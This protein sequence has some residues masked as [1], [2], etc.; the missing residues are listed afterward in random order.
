MD[1]LAWRGFVRVMRPR[2]MVPVSGTRGPAARVMETV[3][4]G[5]SFDFE[6]A[7]VRAPAREE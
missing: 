3:G 6:G 4:W 1:R 2:T 7:E 5:A